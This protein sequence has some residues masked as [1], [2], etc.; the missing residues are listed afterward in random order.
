[1]V[2]V[3]WQL[4]I[5]RIEFD[6]N[7]DAKNIAKHGVSLSLAA[8][9]EW[10]FM[11][12]IEDTREDYGEVRMIGFAPIGQTVYSVVFSEDNDCYRIISLR[13]ALPREVRAYA[14]QI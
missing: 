12:A 13:K 2:V 8:S 11:L 7:K 5:M 10:E 1:M 9:L 6:P 4:G 14:R 3:S